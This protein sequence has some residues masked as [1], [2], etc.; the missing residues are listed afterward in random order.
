MSF[1]VLLINP[2]IAA[3]DEALRARYTVHRLY[4]HAD[5]QGWLRE[6]GA[7]I[8]GVVTGGASGIGNESMD[9]LPKLR[10]VAING[11]GTD[12]VDLDYAR[13][14]NIHVSTTPGVLTDDVAD[15]AL[16][17]LLAACRGLCVGDRYVRDGQWRAKAPL[18]LARKFSDMKVGI[19]G[20]GRV[21]RAIAARA[22]A[23]NCAIGYT[24]L[25]AMPDVPWRYVG[26]LH[27]LASESDALVLAA[28]ADDAEGIVDAHILDALGRDGW[29]V[30][31]ARGKLV[32]EADLVRALVEKRIAGA[33]LDVFVDEP[34][35]PEALFALPN[36]VLQPHRASA[37]V[38]T[39]EAMAKI[40][41]ES[42]EASFA[43][44][45]PDTSVT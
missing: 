37:T 1:E 34:N 35:V 33:G 16:G 26:D 7:R 18:P 38:Q 10:I 14:R 32:N 39:R 6:I 9:R 11:I 27:T 21:G 43:G 17:L 15:L 29:L 36:V 25:R 22:A 23:F 12:A 44:R 40:V 19:V 28:S 45:R 4:E 3:L 20:L 31:V 24:D 42:L 8:D 13:S 2:V 41:L 30:N 5:A